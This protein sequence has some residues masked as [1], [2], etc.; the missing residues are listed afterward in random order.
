MDNPEDN[1]I[2]EVLVPQHYHQT[3]SSRDDGCCVTAWFFDLS[4]AFDRVWH[5]GLLKK[6]EHL[7]VRGPA[8]MWITSYLTRRRQCVRVGEA[9]S[10]WLPIPAGVP[11]GSVLGPLLYLIYTVDLPPT[12]TNTHTK[13]SQF[14]DDT[15]L[16]ATHPNRD[17]AERALQN[18]VAAA[19][20]WLQKWH[21]LVNAT[22]TVVMS[23]SPDHQLRINL[24]SAHLVQVNEH[25]HLGVTIQSNLR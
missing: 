23:F 6:L 17:S 19:A 25:R 14:A 18:S 16:I 7:G 21:L 12:C 20:T 5:A 2:N 10:P 3:T 9:K 15:A 8:H 22:K 4:K 13:C 11:Q 1:Q 24:G